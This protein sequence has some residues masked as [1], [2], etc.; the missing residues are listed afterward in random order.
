MKKLTLL[1][2]KLILSKRLDLWLGYLTFAGL[3]IKLFIPGVPIVSAEQSNSTDYGLLTV[4]AIQ[5]PNLSE[6]LQN[7][8]GNLTLTDN[9]Y[10]LS[11]CSMN[12]PC[13]KNI[14]AF[15]VAPVAVRIPAKSAQLV[16]VTAYS[17]TPDQTDS[18][19]FITA[20]GA[21][22]YD[23]VVAAN[24]LPFGTKVKFPEIYGEK[25]FTV[26]D[27]MA[28]YN[29]HKMDIWMPDRQSALQFGVRKLA[30]E[31]VE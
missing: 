21:Y 1:A 20:N 24:F 11:P 23:G 7:S 2:K 14:S 16:L 25:V 22:V 4:E 28:D 12:N 6:P 29:G 19:P 3:F 26:E 30:Y 27:R 15:S 5:A 8:S 17:S 10:L 18:T 31:I 13:D 9:N